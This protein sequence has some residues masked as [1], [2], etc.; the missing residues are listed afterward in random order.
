MSKV[1]SV[2]FSPNSVFENSIFQWRHNYI[3]ITYCRAGIDGTFYNYSVT[4][5]VRMI[6]AKNCQSCL[7][8]SKLRP[9][10]YR[11]FFLDIWVRGH[12]SSFKLVP[13]ESLGVVFYSPSIVTMA[14]SCTIS[15]IKRDIGRKLWFF[16]TPHAFDAPVRV[17]PSEYCHPVWYGKTRMVGIPQNISMRQ[18]DRRTDR[19]LPMA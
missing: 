15:E 1:L 8:L 17:S 5:T 16:H 9:K 18:T 6:C 3:I 10:Y 7:N 4:R 12:S 14:L 11:S 19:H 13:I 2:L